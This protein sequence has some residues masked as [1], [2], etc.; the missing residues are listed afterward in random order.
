MNACEF[1]Q[2]FFPLLGR[3]LIALIFVISGWGKIT[4]FAG[5]VAYAASK[6]LP[7]PQILMP[8][9]ILVE[10]GGGLALMLGW[11]TRWV[12]FAIFLFVIPTT[13]VFH[14][15]WADPPEQAQMQTI[16]F[17]KN[18]AIMG[19]LLYVMAFGAGPLSVDGTRRR[20][21]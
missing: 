5:S 21:H 11:K 16:Q 4:G 17:L 7:F 18:L 15:F 2:R 13:L 8:A 6:G 19:G 1:V 3:C 14:N 20:R 9:A 12:A 10:L